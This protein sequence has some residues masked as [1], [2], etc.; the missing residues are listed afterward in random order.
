M[1]RLTSES[2]PLGS[3]PA[4]HAVARGTNTVQS[5]GY[6][7]AL[8]EVHPQGQREVG[9]LLFVHG[10]TFPG[11]PDFDL[12]VPVEDPIGFSYMEF[13]ARRGWCC[14]CFDHRGFGASTKPPPGVPFDIPVR[15]RDLAAVV[16]HARG[17]TAGPLVL[18]GISRGCHTISEFLR[19][20]DRAVD[21]AVLLGPGGFGRIPRWY[22][23]LAI[24]ALRIA[25]RWRTKS[26][27]VTNTFETLERRLWRGREAFVHRKAF[28]CF[29]EQAIAAD[30]NGPRDRLESLIG[31]KGQGI[32]R[33]RFRVPVLAVRGGLD[34]EVSPA[35]LEG[36]RRLADAGLVTTREF[37]D[38]HHDL[39]LYKERRDVFDC[40][41][42][43]ARDRLERADGSVTR[44]EP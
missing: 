10:L 5:D 32:R 25:D 29:V 33:Y 6:E 1:D 17:L 11:V 36:V 7:L 19:R 15:A 35:D 4:E 16:E 9:T 27:Y 24:I 12:R 28:E 38:R 21:G 26:R 18:I 14:V 2:S 43:F 22:F 34:H 44:R 39:H 3:V 31:M 42:E 40:I 30:P 37:A 20:D 23:P 8:H 13:L 41:L